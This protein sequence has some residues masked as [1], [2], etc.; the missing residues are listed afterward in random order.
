MQQKNRLVTG[1]ALGLIAAALF[2]VT[3]QADNSFVQYA[4]KYVAEVTNPAIPWTG[5]TA[6]P[7]AVPDK[8]VVYVANDERNGGARGVQAGAA[9]AA[10]VIGW[11][12]R[13]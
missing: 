3:A 5:P 1:T 12:F 6:G 11:K 13:A 2:A 4:K 9:E 8:T 10:K 7:K